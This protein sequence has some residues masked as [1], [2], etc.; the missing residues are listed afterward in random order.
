MQ[1]NA[2]IIDDE[3]L[4]RN[5]IREYLQSHPEVKVLAECKDAH[6]ALRAV[7]ELHP[8][9]IFLDIQMPEINGFELDRIFNLGYHRNAIGQL[10][11]HLI[12][13]PVS[14]LFRQ[15]KLETPI[16][17]QHLLDGQSSTVTPANFYSLAGIQSHSALNDPFI[18]S[19]NQ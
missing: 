3:I 13:Y 8:E 7:E 17:L 18:K 4:G 5:I 6:E 2:I 16:L 19:K 1:I 15:F 9:L 11:P 14:I 12:D 10:P